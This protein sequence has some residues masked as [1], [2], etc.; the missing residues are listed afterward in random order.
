MNDGKHWDL[1]TVNEAEEF[2]Q[3]KL[4]HLASIHSSDE[5]DF[6]Y[7]LLSTYGL[8]SQMTAGNGTP[9]ALGVSW[10]GLSYYPQSKNYVWTDRTKADYIGL[11]ALENTNNVY[12][13]MM[14]DATCTKGWNYQTNDKMA[15]RYVCKKQ[16]AA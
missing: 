9:C 11:P 2:C 14:N 1:S 15:A 7:N 16:P 5:D 3:S 10:I 12:Y 6:V 8:S 4:A 13:A